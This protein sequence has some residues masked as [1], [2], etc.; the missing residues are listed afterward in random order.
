MRILHDPRRHGTRH[1]ALAA[2]AVAAMTAACG[3]TFPVDPATGA[4]VVAGGAPAQEQGGFD[5]GDSG[6]TLEPSTDGGSVATGSAGGF[7]GI[8]S[9]PGTTGGSSGGAG[10]GTSSTTTSTTTSE[11]G[12]ATPAQTSGGQDG[13]RPAAP[14]ARGIDDDQVLV[15]LTYTEDSAAANA[16]LG[17]GGLTGG[18]QKRNYEAL[19]RYF[20]D[21]GGAHGREIV[22]VYHRYEATS[23]QPYAQQEQAACATFT[24]DQPV[25]VSLAGGLQALSDGT[26]NACM[27]AAGTPILA[28]SA[29]S[30]QNDSSFQRWP[31]FVQAPTL[32]LDAIARL[33]PA[34]LDESGYFE[35]RTPAGETRI[36]LL[37]YDTETMRTTA[38]RSLKPALAELGHGFEDERYVRQPSSF[39]DVSD[40][41]AEVQSA[42]LAFRTAGIEHVMI[43]DAGNALL[44]LLFMNG[45][46]SQGYRP[47]YG[48]TTNNGGQLLVGAVPEAQYDDA[49]LVGW[50]PSI[51]VPPSRFDEPMGRGRELCDAIYADAG[52]TFSDGNAQLVAYGQCDEFRVLLAAVEAGSG[53]LA[54]DTF[55]GD[56]LSVGTSFETAVVGPTRFAPDRRYGVARYRLAEFSGDCSCFTYTT[57]W[58]A[59]R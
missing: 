38:E 11:S 49:R 53:P 29:L 59:V 2:A 31:H 47:R 16:A 22:P 33:W 8:G 3:S 30:D 24:E 17:A 28:A 34:G 45:A 46:E 12:G 35:P 37:T 40:M 25:F 32:S 55:T 41:S 7:G 44:T 36:G 19:L 10:A 9:T 6:L 18:D 43:Q 50:H 14:G 58:R 57:P 42:V 26:F 1:R 54:Q 48:L 51:D 27:H 13:A 20:N 56:F 5:G 15:G 4:P 23:N 39:S 52:I 21:R